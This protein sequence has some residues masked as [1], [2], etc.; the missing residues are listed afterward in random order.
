R[1][2]SRLPRGPWLAWHED[3]IAIPPLASELATSPSGPQAFC[4]GRHLGVQF[5]PEVT[6]SLVAR[7]VEAAGSA[8]LPSGAAIVAGARERARAT[9]AGANR[10]STTSA[11]HAGFALQPTIA[12]RT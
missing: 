12:P 10:L 11:R 3:V 2:E 6:P 9:S 1:D 7:W 8:R 5:H 4:M